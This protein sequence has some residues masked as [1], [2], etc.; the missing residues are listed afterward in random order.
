MKR[1]PRAGWCR[2]S[3][4][5]PYT[6]ARGKIPEPRQTESNWILHRT[7]RGI[8]FSTVHIDKGDRRGKCICCRRKSRGTKRRIRPSKPRRQQAKRQ[9]F[10]AFFLP[11]CPLRKFRKFSHYPITPSMLSRSDLF[12]NAACPWPISTHPESDPSGDGGL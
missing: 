9:F 2:L 3:A 10:G 11:F 1:D 5:P 6:A 7:P 8:R 4:I 12:C